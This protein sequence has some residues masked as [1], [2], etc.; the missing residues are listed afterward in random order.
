MI[1]IFDLSPTEALPALRYQLL[2]KNPNDL[3]SLI[4]TVTEVAAERATPIGPWGNSGDRLDWARVALAALEYAR[5]HAFA[6]PEELAIKE[7]SLRAEMIHRLG[8]DADENV[9]SP[10]E[11][12]EL[13][14]GL[15]KLNAAEA[16]KMARS[17]Q[18][19]D[20]PDILELRRIKNALR[21]FQLIHERLPKDVQSWLE[22]WL[23]VLDV[24][25]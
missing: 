6:A 9:T 3:R 25:P 23:P 11:I 4:M 12:V 7:I 10:M 20:P 8:C 17:W 18:T 15:T 22:A 16:T 13:F 2:T 1:E 21:H 5:E 24:L 14:Q 19:L